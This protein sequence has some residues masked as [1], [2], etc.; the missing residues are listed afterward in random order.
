MS[1]NPSPMTPLIAVSEGPFAGWSTWGQDSDPFEALTGPYFMRTLADG[2]YACGF[3]PEARH[4]NG[5]GAVHGGSLMTFADFALFAHAY[6]HMD[7]G[8]C[9]TVQF[10]SQ[11]I[12]AAQPGAMIVSTGEIIRVTR[13][14]IFVRGLMEQQDRPILAYSGILKRVG[15]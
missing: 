5:M 4:L 15:R 2:G 8:P 10:E 14:L 11:F 3:M 1:E 13:S 6:D 12:G 9:V 7:G